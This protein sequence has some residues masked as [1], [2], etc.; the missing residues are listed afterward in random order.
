MGVEIQD[1]QSLVE[2]FIM[3]GIE[4]LVYDTTG[5]NQNSLF[6]SLRSHIERNGRPNNYLVNES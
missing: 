2:Y 5:K 1:M 4:E 3:N 6:E